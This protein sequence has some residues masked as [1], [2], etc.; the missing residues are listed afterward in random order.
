MNIIIY[1]HVASNTEAKHKVKSAIEH[2]GLIYRNFDKYIKDPD[3]LCAFMKSYI[4]IVDYRYMS[5]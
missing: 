4:S 1:Y 5:C 3:V 2:V